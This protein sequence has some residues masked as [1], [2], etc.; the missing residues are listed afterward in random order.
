MFKKTLDFLF[1]KAPQIFDKDGQVRH[2]LSKEKWQ[3]WEHRFQTKDYDWKH[4]KG[5]DAG[6][7]SNTKKSPQ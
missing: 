5:K 3:S 7:G 6:G 2:H 1:G 4:H